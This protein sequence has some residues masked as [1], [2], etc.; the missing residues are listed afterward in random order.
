MFEVM[1]EP[2]AVV[3][4][5]GFV[6][7]GEGTDADWDDELTDADLLALGMSTVPP[8]PPPPWHVS[9]DQ[10]R[11]SVES[12]VDGAGLVERLLH[13]GPA[14]ERTEIEMVDHVDW[15]GRALAFCQA[16]QAREVAALLAQREAQPVDPQNPFATDPLRDTCAQVALALRQSPR[17][18]EQVVADSHLLTQWPAT[19]DAWERG[20]IDVATARAISDEASLVTEEYRA[21]LEAAALAQA[22]KGAT[23]RQVRLFTRRVAIKLDPSAAAERAKAAK[24]DRGVSKTEVVDDM[25][26]LRAVLTAEEL[27][28]CWG[29]LS[30]R[31]D[32]LPT[33]DAAGR[34]RPLEERRA[35]VLVDLILH[36]DRV[37][38]CTHKDATRWRTDLV[39]SASTAAG[40]DDEPAELVG[41]GLLT[42]PTARRM[43]AGSTWR[44]LDVDASGQVVAIGLRQA[45]PPDQAPA[46]P[47]DPAAADLR[48]RVSALLDDA[49]PTTPAHRST[50]RYRPT[51]AITEQVVARHQHC[52]FPGCRRPSA[53]CDLDHGDAYGKG[54]ETCSCNL[55][56]LCRFHH[57]VKHL[58]GWSIEIHADGSVAW[59]TPT[60]HRYRAPPPTVW[61]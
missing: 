59:T 57:R 6:R 45:P 19:A 21:V 25:G 41:Y 37:R 34:H 26:E 47:D 39:I 5:A 54:G 20:R 50:D 7:A 61:D 14:G 36:P 11:G 56:P 1:A 18:A 4:R 31:A 2:G 15:W 42:A 10:L 49:S 48:G 38:D 30:A 46:D 53:D 24:V 13:T 52:R 16:M 32:A 28:A 51:V 29:E 33:T 35:D 60:G 8:N 9:A 27:K 43:A 55:I 58:V 23:A 17:A 44:R 40:E 3:D 22:E 12:G